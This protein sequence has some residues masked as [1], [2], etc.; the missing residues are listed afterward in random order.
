V[1]KPGGILAVTE[2]FQDPDYPL[3]STTIRDGT[4]AGL[5]L[6]ATEGNFWYYTVRFEK[7][8]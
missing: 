4:N 5:R 7:P 6:Q 3:V 8:E 2:L 1:L